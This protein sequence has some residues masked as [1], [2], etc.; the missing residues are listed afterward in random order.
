[1]PQKAIDDRGVDRFQRE[2]AKREP[3]QKVTGPGHI[4]ADTAFGN[5]PAT[6]QVGGELKYDRVVLN[7]CF[8]CNSLVFEW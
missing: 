7:R 8:V 3:D 6:T 5:L 2:A 1:M 4:V